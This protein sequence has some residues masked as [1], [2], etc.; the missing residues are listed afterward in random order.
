[1]RAYLI[2]DEGTF[3]KLAILKYQEEENRSNKSKEENVI[4]AGRET[5]NSS[6]GS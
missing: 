4:N 5:P 6:I 2:K 3:E 1:M